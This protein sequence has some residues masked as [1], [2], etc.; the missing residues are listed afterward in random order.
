M[1]DDIYDL[2]VNIEPLGRSDIQQLIEDTFIHEVGVVNMNNRVFDKVTITSGTFEKSIDKLQNEGVVRT[3]EIDEVDDG[4]KSTDSKTVVEPSLE[5]QGELMNTLDLV[6][7]WRMQSTP[8]VV[9]SVVD[10]RIERVTD[11][12]EFKENDFL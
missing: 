6:S 2:H 10:E 8:A 1:K 12:T 5:R 9:D 4:E 7:K 11:N 3:F